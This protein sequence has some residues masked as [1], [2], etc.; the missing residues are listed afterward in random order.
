M[1]NPFLRY[2]LEYLEIHNR[3]DI[4]AIRI[5]VAYEFNCK[6]VMVLTKKNAKLEGSFVEIFGSRFDQSAAHVLKLPT[7]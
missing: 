3:V 2:W 7:H 4:E 1:F 5:P 6:S